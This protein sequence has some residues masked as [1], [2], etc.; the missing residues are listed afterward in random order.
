[1]AELYLIGT[2]YIDIGG[3]RKLQSVLY[4]IEPDVIL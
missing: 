1:M 2:Y 3:P 4:K